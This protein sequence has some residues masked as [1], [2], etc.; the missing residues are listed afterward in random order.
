MIVLPAQTLNI[1]TPTGVEPLWYQILTQ[2]ASGGLI[3]RGAM[4]PSATSGFGYMP[5][6]AGPPTGIPVP[7]AGYVPFVYDTTNNKLWAFN[8]ASWRGVALV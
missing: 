7:R 6:C 3:G 1:D 5:T 2:M 8:G 4:L